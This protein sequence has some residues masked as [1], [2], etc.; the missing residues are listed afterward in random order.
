MINLQQK[1]GDT[2]SKQPSFVPQASKDKWCKRFES[3]A[4]PLR[5]TE[6]QKC[7]NAK[8]VVQSVL[9]QN[10]PFGFNLGVFVQGSIN[11]GGNRI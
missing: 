5:Q 10:G 9:N 8:S 4:K 2:F 11:T 1:Q 3:L 7:E 6:K